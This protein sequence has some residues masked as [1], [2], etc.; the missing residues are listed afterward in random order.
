METMNQARSW[1]TPEKSAA[2]KNSSTWS[3]INI[4]VTESA[5]PG[6]K[7]HRINVLVN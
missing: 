4:Y 6:R 5:T 3:L 2:N 1:S 7:P